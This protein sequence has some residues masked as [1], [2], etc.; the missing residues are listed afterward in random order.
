MK[1]LQG[2][3]ISKGICIGKAF[4]Y[5]VEPLEINNKEKDN[6]PVEKKEEILQK[7]IKASE[8][9]IQ[10]LYKR[11]K[12]RGSDKEAEIFQAHLL[13]LKDPSIAKRIRYFLRKGS[14]LVPS[15]K[16]AFGEMAQ[17]I[18][19]MENTYFRERAKDIRDVSERLIRSILHKPKP[20]LSSL[21]CLRKTH[22]IYPA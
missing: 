18:E 2:I 21:G 22:K 8:K 5:I 4:L 16:K 9:E 1:K 14:S 11:M 12:A 19:Q 3:G 15:I 7:S 20:N 10:E 13:F 6:I 17:K